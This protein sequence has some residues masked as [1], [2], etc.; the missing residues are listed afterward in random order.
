MF[1]VC[2]AES[3][4]VSAQIGSGVV[5]GGPQLRFHE[6][7]TRVP[8][9]F[10]Q[11]LRVVRGG[12][13]STRALRGQRVVRGWFEVKFQVLQGG[14][15]WFEVRFHQASTRFHQ[16]STRFCK[17]CGVVWG[18]LRQVPPGF[19]QVLRWPWWFEV[20][21][22][23]SSTRVLPGLRGVRGGLRPGSTHHGSTRFNVRIHKGYQVLQGWFE[24]IPP[25]FHQIV[26]G[27]RGGPGW[28]EVRFHKHSPPGFHLRGLRGGPGWF[29][30]VPQ[31]LRQSSTRVPKKV[32]KGSTE[33]REDSTRVPQGSKRFHKGSARFHGL[34]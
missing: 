26:R 2:R 28:F 18:G 34:P 10:H 19:H 15:G 1:P 7:S 17:G 9:E 29:E 5:R 13:G 25:G 32:S 3:F 24:V 6:G 22:H 33:F 30:K 27:L 4:G 20:R 23:D 14:P 12:L 8:P 31:K 16:G 21:F 11:V